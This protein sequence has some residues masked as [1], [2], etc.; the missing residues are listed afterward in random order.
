M[1][2]WLISSSI[3]LNIRWGLWNEGIFWIKI[4]TT[5]KWIIRAGQGTWLSTAECTCLGN[6]WS[7][8]SRAC[9]SIV[10]NWWLWRWC[11]VVD[12]TGFTSCGVF[13]EG[14]GFCVWRTTFPY[15]FLCNCCE[16]IMNHKMM[17]GMWIGWIQWSWGI[18]MIG[19]GRDWDWMVGWIVW[20]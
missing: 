8:Y 2:S 11:F 14:I 12:C 13:L 10:R 3:G 5:N 6:R 15:R 18:L 9:F 7:L 16:L 1:S 4:K 19:C 17:R 20:G